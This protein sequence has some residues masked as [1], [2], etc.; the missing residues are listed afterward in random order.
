MAVLKAVI[1][2]VED[3]PALQE[4][5]VEELEAEGYQVSAWGSLEEFQCSKASPDLIVSDIRLPGKSGL[6]LLES[7]KQQDN[8]PALLLI[9][10]FGTVDQAVDALKKG[11]DDFLTKPLDIEHLLLSVDR[12][13]EHR[14]LQR[15]LKRYKQQQKGPGGLV[16]QSPAM[17]KLYDQIEHIAPTGGSVLIT[18]ESGTGKELVAKALHELSDRA[19]KPFQAVNCAGIPAD[20]MESEFF[21]HAAGA[22]TGA[23]NKRQGLLKQ[24][25][26]GTLLLDEIGE[27]PMAL[28]AK[29]L[30]VLQ[31][32]T[33]RAVGSDKEEQVNVRILAATHQDLERLVEEGKFRQ[34]LFY[35]LETFSLRVPPLRERGEDIERLANF[36]LQQQQESSDKTVRG[37]SAEALDLLYRYPFPGNVRELQNAIERAFAF[38]SDDTL[39]VDDFPQRIVEKSDTSQPAATS[40][41][42]TL[43]EYQ[44]QYIRK[45]LEHTDGNKSQAAQIL[46]VTRRTLYRWLDN[47]SE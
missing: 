41:W 31:E 29:L 27:M 18:G 10:A 11:A 25:D 3:D 16:G 28:Q 23:Q 30:R 42:P 21:G 24:A 34:D 33:I 40:A 5:L 8:P 6:T 15:E 14:S 35:R 26:G 9:T 20:L 44:S 47:A 39:S 45:V 32:G 19:D 12:I 46:G 36:F 1:G 7:L 13:L 37:I 4:L 22:F 38:S 2:V 17:R 43:D